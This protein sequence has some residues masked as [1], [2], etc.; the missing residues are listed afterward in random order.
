M[1]P[2]DYENYNKPALPNSLDNGA[3]LFANTTAGKT[4]TL[5]ESTMANSAITSASVSTTAVALAQF[6]DDS[7]GN[8]LINTTTVAGGCASNGQE[9]DEDGY[10]IQPPKEIILEAN[11]NKDG[12]Y[13]F[14]I[15]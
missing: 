14:I 15:K 5:T 6:S 11:G 4:G 8:G 9:V 12:K 1:S 7:N 10:S 3:N 13:L 2:L